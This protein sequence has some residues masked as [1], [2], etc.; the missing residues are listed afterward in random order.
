[1]RPSTRPLLRALLLAL[2][3]ASVAGCAAGP[4]AEPA[5]RP[6]WRVFELEDATFG[7]NES[8]DVIRVVAP[9]ETASRW[10][11][12]SVNATEEGF[13]V[14]FNREATRDAGAPV[15][16]NGAL[17]LRD[18]HDGP[19]REDDYL[20]FCADAGTRNETWIQLRTAPLPVVSERAYRMRDV[21]AC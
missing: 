16:V 7:Y 15:P 4:D 18:L 13:R 21:A 10:S 2:L 20:S 3:A 1:M 9:G 8:R 11:D 12:F 5:P 17:R 6:A 19:L 14:A